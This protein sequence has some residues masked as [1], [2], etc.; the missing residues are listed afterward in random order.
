M[1][2]QNV[3]DLRYQI[4]WMFTVRL[5][6]DQAFIVSKLDNLLIGVDVVFKQNF[7]LMS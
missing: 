4:R 1:V 7:K 2:V 5:K 6:A 3:Q